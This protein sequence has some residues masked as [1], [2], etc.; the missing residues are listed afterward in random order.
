MFTSPFVDS[1]T[2]KKNYGLFTLYETKFDD[3]DSITAIGFLN[4]FYWI[5]YPEQ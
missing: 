5:D 3:K 4:N 1:F 2:S